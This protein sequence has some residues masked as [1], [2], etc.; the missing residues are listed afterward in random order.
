MKKVYLFLQIIILFGVYSITVGNEKDELGEPLK[1]SENPEA[2]VPL[3]NDN[4]WVFEQIETKSD[5]KIV[6]SFYKQFITLNNEKNWLFKHRTGSNADTMKIT[7]TFEKFVSYSKDGINWDKAISADE[8]FTYNAKEGGLLINGWLNK[9]NKSYIDK[10]HT[11][12]TK[13][14]YEKD[15]VIILNN[16]KYNCLKYDFS[17]ATE[18]KMYRILCYCKGV[19]LVYK[20]IN[21]AGEISEIKLKAYKVK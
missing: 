20:Y 16:I 13:N 18:P 5:G 10:H 9:H 7:P 11:F 6:K 3:A 2:V 14:C 19:G 8:F 4:E 21:K 1:S 15:T 17:T 12:C